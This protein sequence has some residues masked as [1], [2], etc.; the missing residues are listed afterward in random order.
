MLMHST[1]LFEVI[2]SKKWQLEKFKKYFYTRLSH[3]MFVAD[4]LMRLFTSVLA[5]KLAHAKRKFHS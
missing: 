1:H 2:D 5:Q 4:T 3:R